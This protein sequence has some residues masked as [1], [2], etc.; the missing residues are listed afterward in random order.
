MATD[1]LLTHCYLADTRLVN[2]GI[3]GGRIATIG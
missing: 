3:A 2:I 1:A